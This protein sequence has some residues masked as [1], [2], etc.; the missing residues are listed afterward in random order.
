M[1]LADGVDQMAE[2]GAEPVELPDHQRVPGRQCG[3]ACIQPRPAVAGTRDAVLI[4]P[5]GIDA[6]GDQRIVLQVMDLTAISLGY[7]GVA[8]H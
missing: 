6:C 7:A 2:A 8:D 1:P 4:D 5:L 3:E